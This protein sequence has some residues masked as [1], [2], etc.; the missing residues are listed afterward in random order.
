MPSDADALK[1]NKELVTE[2]I[3]RF[4]NEKDYD[5]ARALLT[6]D[7][8]NHHPGVGVGRDRTVEGFREAAQ[9]AFPAFS[10]T[11]V[12]MVAEGDQVWTHSVARVAP[13]APGSVVVDIW[14]IRD[15]RLAEHWDVGQAVPEGSTL[16]ELTADGL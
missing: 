14:R 8:A 11:V 3:R 4:Y 1:A 16:E 9:A 10:L 2:F 13:T 15:G 12:R 5:R 6:E 7:F